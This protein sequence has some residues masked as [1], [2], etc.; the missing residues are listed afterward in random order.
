[1][2]RAVCSRWGD[3]ELPFI[4]GWLCFFVAGCFYTN[5]TRGEELGDTYFGGRGRL[6]VSFSASSWAGILLT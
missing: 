3:H 5:W 1:M 2:Y 4:S 6:M